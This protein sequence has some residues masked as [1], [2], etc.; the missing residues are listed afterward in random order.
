VLRERQS[1]GE[2]ALLVG[3]IGDQAAR[4]GDL[5]VPCAGGVPHKLLK[6]L[7]A[8]PEPWIDGN[9][10]CRRRDHQSVALT[11]IGEC[12]GT[13]LRTR[14]GPQ[15][16]V[17]RSLPE[18]DPQLVLPLG[19]DASPFQ[20]VWAVNEGRGDVPA[21][22]GGATP[23]GNPAT[24]LHQWT[25]NAGAIGLPRVSAGSRYRQSFQYGPGA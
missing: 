5:V 20:L 3:P 19:E 2:A 12:L 1:G 8:G 16:G 9:E 22:G 18:N 11:R 6:D 14:R 10:L 7:H 13:V 21:T 23:R 15:K 24:F 17:T 25:G 4:A